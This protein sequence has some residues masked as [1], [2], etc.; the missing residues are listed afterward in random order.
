MFEVFQNDVQM[1]AG[2]CAHLV[3]GIHPAG[4][5]FGA[6]EVAERVGPPRQ[7][8]GRAPVNRPR[9]GRHEPDDE[10]DALLVRQIGARPVGDVRR[11][12]RQLPRGEPHVHDVRRPRAQETRLEAST[13]EPQPAPAAE[14]ARPVA[15]SPTPRSCRTP[16]RIGPRDAAAT[17]NAA[18]AYDDARP[19]L[20]T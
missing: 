18:R 5:R 14:I 11:V 9:V 4:G 2:R 12:Q 1:L 16:G 19:G 7:Q 17:P 13:P 6:R 20:G 10:P 8:N 3:E 15:M